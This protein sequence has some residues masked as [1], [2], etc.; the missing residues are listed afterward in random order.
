MIPYTAIGIGVSFIL[1]VWAFTLAETNGGRIFIAGAMVFLFF[2]RVLWRGGAGG[3]VW[4]VGWMLFGIGCLI[5][6][7]TRGVGIR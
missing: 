6:I 1:G 3:I 2:L 5:F 7:R 4:L